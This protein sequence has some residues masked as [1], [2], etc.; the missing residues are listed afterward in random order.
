VAVGG[1]VE[2]GVDV[3]CWQFTVFPET[4]R[5][6]TDTGCPPLFVLV[7]VRPLIENS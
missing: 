4:G 5:P 1:V 3:A 2:V 7:P 6:V